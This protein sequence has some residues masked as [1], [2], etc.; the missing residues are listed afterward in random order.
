MAESVKER[1]AVRGYRIK[2]YSDLETICFL[3]KREEMEV[4]ITVYRGEN[5]KNITSTFCSEHP[6]Y[7]S[8]FQVIFIYETIID[9][10]SR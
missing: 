6:I 9:S 2:K 1:T 7:A 5:E 3:C 4:R 8:T 10:F